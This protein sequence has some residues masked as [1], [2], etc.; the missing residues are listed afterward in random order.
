ME[1]WHLDG[2]DVPTYVVGAAD[3]KTVVVFVHDIFSPNEGRAKALCDFLADNGCRVVFPDWH[4]GDYMV[5]EGNF[6]Q[7][8]GI[9]SKKHP[10]D[11]VVKMVAETCN[12]VREEGKKLVTVGTCWGTWVLY[13][14][15][16]TGV[17]M[18]G[19]VCMHPSLANENHTG[20]N[21]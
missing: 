12:K 16:V 18:D 17:Q 7:N 5:K 4:K 19:C 1:T 14:A 3:S 2:Q 10:V 20:G 9:W 13:R 11:E 6:M 21:Y 15:Q 8:Y